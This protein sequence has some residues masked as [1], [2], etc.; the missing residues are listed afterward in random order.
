[1][2]VARSAVDL[3]RTLRGQAGL[4][5]RQ[6]L[7]TL[8]L[9]LPG[10]DLD[11]LDALL[12]V[13]RAEANVKTVERIGDE[14]ELVDRRRQ[15]PAAEGRQ[16]ARGADPGGDG[17]GP[18]GQRRDPRGRLRDRRRR[19]ARGG[20]G[21]GPGDPAARHRGRPPRRRRRRDRHHPHARA[22]RRGRRAR[23]PARDPGPAQ[24]RGA[25]ARRP[26][27]RLG[28]RRG[29][30]AR[31]VPRVGRRGDPRRR[32]RARAGAR[33]AC[34]RPPC[35]W[36]AARPG[37]G[38]GVSGRP[39]PVDQAADPG[40]ELDVEIVDDDDPASPRRRRPRRGG[41]RRSGAGSCSR[42][43]A[44]GVVVV[45]QA[46]KAWI[47]SN[48]DPGESMTVLGDWLRF[49]HGQNSGI[50][51][52]L[53]PQSAPIFA[54]VSLGVTA[55]IVA[56]HRRAGRGILVTVALGLLLGGAIG[57]LLDRLNHGYVVDF[58]DMGIGSA[59]VLHLQPRRRLHH[60]V[61]PDPAP[62]WPRCPR[63]PSGA[64]MTD[65]AERRDGASRRSTPSTPTTRSTTVVRG[66]AAVH[67]ARPAPA[68]GPGGRGRAPGGPVR[69][70]PDRPVALVR[71][72]AD[73]RRPPRGRRRAGG[74]APTPRSGA[75]AS[76]SRSRRPRSRTTW[77][78]TRRS[79]SRSSTR[80]TTC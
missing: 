26:D 45:D 44:I 78:P 19:D 9:A 48:L 33:T 59:A 41:A 76:P 3:S 39:E 4:K 31:P 40:D 54:I 65:E 14:S 70:G 68:P 16:A 22:A 55:L 57:N 37:S 23:A 8:W 61:D 36:T 12:E 66:P 67:R 47:T 1:M 51:F 77:S 43:I 50:L 30:G 24:G 64:P 71:P 79:R 60:H 69:R 53:L 11:D 58:V 62:R 13:I 28:R 38:S 7:A 63:S 25:G 42:A 15:G 52:G 72:E 20:R 74:S 56:Y 34:A 21:R 5:V 18:R 49:V 10:R 29:G 6:P 27:P 32:A 80:T 17:G 35:G 46:A 2:A 73:L 75:A